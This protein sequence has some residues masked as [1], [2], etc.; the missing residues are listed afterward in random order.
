MSIIY[1]SFSELHSSDTAAV[2]F[3]TVIF[4][5]QR[6]SLLLEVKLIQH[7]ELPSGSLGSHGNKTRRACVVHGNYES[8][9]S[10]INVC[11]DSSDTLSNLIQRMGCSITGYFLAD[12]LL[13]NLLVPLVLI[14]CLSSLAHPLLTG[15]LCFLLTKAGLQ[16]SSRELHFVSAYLQFVL[17]QVL[18]Y[19][20]S[21]KPAS[22][23][24]LLWDKVS[25]SLGLHRWNGA[26]FTV[27]VLLK[28]KRNSMKN[29]LSVS[30]DSHW[31]VCL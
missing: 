6:S 15:D 23:A 22:Y 14:F 3:H 9:S 2:L 30:E 20:Y 24:D 8:S 29:I 21:Q 26:T 18:L 17:C 5:N 4:T 28:F 25:D 16:V 7:W 19:S 1:I 12:L 31:N 10:G 13:Y 11:L 27:D